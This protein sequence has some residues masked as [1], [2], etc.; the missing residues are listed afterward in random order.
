VFYKFYE[1]EKGLAINN[2]YVERKVKE[3]KYVKI[4]SIGN[5]GCITFYKRWK[6]NTVVSCYNCVLI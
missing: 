1:G 2:S 5:A 6:D 4:K 3:S